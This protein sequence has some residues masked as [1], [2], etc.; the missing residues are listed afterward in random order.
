M[1]VKRSDKSETS[2]REIITE[3]LVNAPRD[4]VFKAWSNEAM[5]S[6]WWGPNGFSTTI[7]T[8]EF[9][10]GGKWRFVM[11]GPDGRDY[12]N[13]IVY[14]EIAAPERI[15]YKHGDDEPGGAQPIS[16]ETTV[17][18]DA[19]G[20]KTLVTLRTIFPSN[21]ERDRVAKLSGA[22]EGGRQTLARMAAF[23]EEAV[24]QLKPFTISRTFEAPR[25]LVWEVHT[26]PEH[27]ERWWGPK[28]CKLG[29]ER[30]EFRPG[31]IFHYSMRYSNGAAM[32]GRFLYRELDAPTRMVY[33][34]SFANELGGIARAP[35]G[36]LPFELQNTVTLTEKDGKTT[37]SIHTVPF[38]A[39]AEEI[40]FFDNL[41]ETKS[42]EQGFGGTLDQLAAYLAEV[43]KA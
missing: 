40:A 23:S 29:V 22:V 32:W 14:T 2:D 12:K 18:F 1:S 37:L 15:S 34:S 30:L 24:A 13:L 26:K 39:N 35:F 36:P 17:T 42:L 20:S 43:A 6:Q 21:A 25:S 41:R 27:L 8:M 38:G 16:F 7:D 9:K 3:R 31:G 19:Q 4:L 10:P 11:H 33:F 5:I 28:G